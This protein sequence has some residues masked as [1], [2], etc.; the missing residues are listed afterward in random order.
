MTPQQQQQRESRV[1]WS[2]IPVAEMDRA[3]RFHET[4]LAASLNRGQ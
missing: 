3:R 4:V 1:V 2:E